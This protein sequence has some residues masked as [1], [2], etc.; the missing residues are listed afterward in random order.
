MTEMP[1][2]QPPEGGGEGPE[3]V[4][5][6]IG[7]ALAKMAVGLA[8]VSPELGDR[9]N[10]VVSEFQAIMSEAAQSGG[11]APPP[12]ASR[13]MPMEAGARGVPA[14]PNVRS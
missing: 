11:E 12:Q 4:I 9:M 3:Q 5:V 7:N 6:K 2:E 8:E 14:G 10:G 13:Q 1:Q